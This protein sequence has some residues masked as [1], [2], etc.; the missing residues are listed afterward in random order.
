M[1]EG[2]AGMP[3]ERPTP[4]Q[5]A[6]IHAWFDDERLLEIADS[7]FSASADKIA[8]LLAATAPLPQDPRPSDPAELAQAV[9]KELRKLGFRQKMEQYAPCT[10]MLPAWDARGRLSI[11]FV[12]TTD[13]KFDNLGPRAIAD[14]I[15]QEEA[16][17][18][19][20]WAG[21]T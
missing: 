5:I 4:G 20:E 19:A 7:G 15:Q 17:R 12:H 21:D 6:E 8:A 9:A 11:T 18:A 2:M 3:I 16:K 1:G 14:V 13:S 10:I